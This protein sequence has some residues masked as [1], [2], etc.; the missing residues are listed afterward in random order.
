MTGSLDDVVVTVA[1]FACVLTSWPLTLFGWAPLSCSCSSSVSESEEDDEAT[2][3][4]SS[5]ACFS[6]SRALPFPSS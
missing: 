1:D 4:V 3:T 5:L 2:E 6:F